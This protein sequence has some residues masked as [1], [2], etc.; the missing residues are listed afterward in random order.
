MLRPD[1]ITN[2]DRKSVV[3]IASCKL[4]ASVSESGL[5]KLGPSLDTYSEQATIDW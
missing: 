3:V 2:A 1:D 5:H 4:L